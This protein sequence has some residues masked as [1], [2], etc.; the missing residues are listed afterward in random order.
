[1]MTTPDVT[2]PTSSPRTPEALVALADGVWI[3]RAPVRFLGL[4]LTSTMV[5]FRLADSNLM[6]SSPVALT[7]ERRAAVEALG[8][9]THLYAPNLFHHLW[10]GDWATA[11]PGARLHAPGGLSRKHPGLRVDRLHGAEAAPEPAFAGVI[12][13]LPIEGFR[14]R[15]TALF[16]RPTRTLA[17]ADLVCNVGRPTHG[18]T[19]TYARAMGFYDRI[20]LSRVIRWTGFDE[21]K[22]A[23]RSLSGI[24]ERRFDRVIVGHGE[25]VLAGGR[26]ALA[27]AYGWL[28]GR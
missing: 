7:P 12:D 18:W 25:P 17:V 13:E 10:I 4:R 23:R 21:K 22:A 2:G 3:A 8:R 24:L 11:F 16:H 27:G 20:A 15:E 28:L 19:A 5:I 9:V 1:M 14:L 6:V 26:D